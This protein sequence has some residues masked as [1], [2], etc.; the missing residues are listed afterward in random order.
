MGYIGISLGLCRAS[1][2]GFNLWG[3]GRWVVGIPDLTAFVAVGVLSADSKGIARVMI[4]GLLLI[5]ASKDRRTCGK[6]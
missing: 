5:D 6:I 3:L 2:F 4:T 1:G